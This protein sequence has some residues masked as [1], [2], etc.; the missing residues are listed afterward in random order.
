M[1]SRLKPFAVYRRGV[2]VAVFEDK[3]SAERE[4]AYSPPF[5]GPGTVVK[6]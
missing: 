6:R 3:Q 2:K 5:W 4:A 1:Q